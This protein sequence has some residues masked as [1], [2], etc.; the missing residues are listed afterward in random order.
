MMGPTGAPAWLYLG[1]WGL[2]TRRPYLGCA[3]TPSRACM[4]LFSMWVRHQQGCA[5]RYG[6]SGFEWEVTQDNLGD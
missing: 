6:G 5:R 1:T 3:G 2:T 4:M